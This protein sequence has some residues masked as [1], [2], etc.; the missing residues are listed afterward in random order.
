MP[1]NVPKQHIFQC[2]VMN[3]SEQPKQTQNRACFEVGREEWVGYRVVAGSPSYGCVVPK[4]QT[5]QV[6]RHVRDVRRWWVY[7]NGR[8]T[9]IQSSFSWPMPSAPFLLLSV[10]AFVVATWC[11][12]RTKRVHK[13]I[14]IMM[15]SLHLLMQAPCW[16]SWP[17][18]S[19]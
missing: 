4:F 18:S 11:E 1:K 6:P 3:L 13:L 10:A 2:P 17:L 5:W 16:Q 12:N 19:G 8:H 14:M 15:V 7:R 9:Q